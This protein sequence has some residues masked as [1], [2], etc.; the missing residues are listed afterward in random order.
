MKT[1]F[2]FLFLIPI[3]LLAWDKNHCDKILNQA[4]QAT[5]EG[6]LATH[7]LRQGVLERQGNIQIFTQAIS[8][9]EK[10]IGFFDMLLSDFQ[11]DAKSN[12]RKNYKSTCEE[13]KNPVKTL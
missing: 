1:K 12:W 8:S 7:Q 11:K 5:N 4:N 3:F 9:F 6:L 10:A 2:F 13:Q